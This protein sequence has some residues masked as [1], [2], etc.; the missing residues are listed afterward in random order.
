MTTNT[1]A[2]AEGTRKGLEEAWAAA[3]PVVPG[4]YADK[5]Q[6][7]WECHAGFPRFTIIS[8]GAEQP[9]PI[10]LQGRPSSRRSL[11]LASSCGYAPTC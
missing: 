7:I 5:R 9:P 3:L 8:D 11:C 10:R 6:Q 4:W 1:S 2:R